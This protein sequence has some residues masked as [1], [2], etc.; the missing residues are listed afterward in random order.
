MIDAT[1]I[2]DS[3]RFSSRLSVRSFGKLS[4][5]PERLR[6]PLCPICRSSRL[7][8]ED[9][10]DTTYAKRSQLTASTP[11]Q[12]ISHQTSELKIC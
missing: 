8:S 4:D 3:R 2:H 12:R 6:I 11:E 1:S 10:I 5:S 9:E 7:T